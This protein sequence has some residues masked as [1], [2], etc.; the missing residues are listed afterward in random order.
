M[1][2]D[3][4]KSFMSTF[5]GVLGILVAF[6]FSIMVLAGILSGKQD[7]A[8][9]EALARVQQRIA[10]IGN[11][12]TDPSALVKVSTAAAHAPMTGAQ[13]VSGTCSQCH[14]TGMLGSPKIGDKA[15]WGARLKTDGGV[16]GLLANA[17]KG[18]GNMPARGGNADLSDG[19]V[20]AAI[21]EMLKQ[22]GV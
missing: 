18:K 16:D 19:E 22:T 1:S 3:H 9:A 20:K 7:T 6:T 13:I 8:D 12:V 11:V 10:P 5:L 2:S 4:D 15:A 14:G 21:Q 17:L